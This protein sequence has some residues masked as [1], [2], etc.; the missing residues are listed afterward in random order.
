M[1]LTRILF[2]ALILL[3]SCSKDR[4]GRIPEVYINYHAPLSDP[5]LSRLNSA[6]GA[7]LIENHGI[8]GLI[9][10]KRADNAY[11]A[12][13]R[14]SSVNPE[15]R[16]AVTLDDPNLTVT[17]PCSGAKFS[18]YDGNPV[19]APAKRPLKQYQVNISN[20]TI[21]VVN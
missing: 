16:C 5:R 8:A 2:L 17:D 15:K 18:L 11:V 20:F 13:D 1:I 19:K 21:S 4:E 3:S 14:C 6:G 7:V 12:Y 9:I 10:Y